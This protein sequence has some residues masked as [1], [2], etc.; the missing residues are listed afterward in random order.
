MHHKP[1]NIL[2]I[3]ADD[4][5][6]W[7]MGCAG[8]KELKTPNIDRLAREGMRFEN[9]YCASPVCSPA[10]ASLLTGRIPSFH[11]VHDWLR[12]G[13]VDAEKF[14]QAGAENP[15]GHYA[16]EREPIQYLKGQTCY[17][18]LMQQKGYSC[19][20][21]GK[22]HL[23]DSVTPQHGFS[24]WFTIGKGGCYYYH[25]DIVEDGQITV[26]HGEYVTDLITGRALQFLD[27]LAAEPAPFYLGLHRH[28]GC[29]RSPG[30]DH[31]AG[32][33]DAQA[34]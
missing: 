26:R 25:P 24:R 11:G 16:D 12:S 13:N 33:R 20:L 9:F 10:R 30:H 3:L 4:Q 32:L 2:Y 29:T 6:A 14:A 7:A 8:A 18:D 31:R 27:E 17:T 23:G 28:A 19:A 5:G 21:S 15:Y 34:P 22:W 1:L